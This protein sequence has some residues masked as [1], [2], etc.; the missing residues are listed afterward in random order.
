MINTNENLQENCPDN[1]IIEE[2]NINPE[3]V[4]K[5]RGR[6]PKNKTVNT[7]LEKTNE[8]NITDNNLNNELIEQEKPPPKK[9]GRKPKGGKIVAC[10]SQIKDNEIVK[11]N[12]ILHLKCNVKD[13]ECEISNTLTSNNDILTDKSKIN[14]LNYE[15]IQNNNVQNTDLNINTKN[16]VR[17][18]NTL[19]NT[20]SNDC[21]F[22]NRNTDFDEKIKDEVTKDI[23]LKLK[24]LQT[25]L[26]NNDVSDKQSACFWCTYSFD[27]P[28]IFIP[29][30]KI[31]NN[32]QVYGCFCSPECATSYLYNE[33]IDTSIKFERYQLINYIYSKIY[34]YKKSIK[35]APNPYYLLDKYYGNLTISEYRKLLQNDRL[36]MV[37]DKPLTR[38]L[39][40]LHEENNDF[41]LTTQNENTNTGIY[42]VKKKTTKTITKNSIVNENFGFLTLDK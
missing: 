38:I 11:Q 8:I 35:P 27:N 40:E 13:I 18:N 25:Q 31:G 16:I 29:K 5:K 19:N 28:S 3:P 42:Q 12:I 6:K 22:I 20:S 9:R 41:L 32:Y 17:N 21:N 7:N 1:L 2:A 37:I 33:N 23:N 39:P 10:T 30:Y 15:I 14:P 34:N 24:E 26:H 36:L 4:K